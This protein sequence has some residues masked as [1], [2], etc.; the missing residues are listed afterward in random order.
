M[1]GKLF[2]GLLA[3]IVLLG[4]FKIYHDSKSSKTWP[5]TVYVDKIPEN[6]R[7][8]G[9]SKPACIYQIQ[10]GGIEIA[11]CEA[12]ARAEEKKASHEQ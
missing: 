10:G 4:I 7:V 6:V 1:S 5:P 3:L 2:A 11:P 12:A 8:P 9:S